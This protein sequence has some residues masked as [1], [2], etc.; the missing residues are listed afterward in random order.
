LTRKS[1]LTPVSG[2]YVK[3]FGKAYTLSG[4]SL[5]AAVIKHLREGHKPR[6]KLAA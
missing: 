1:C 5:S 3:S 4:E 2:R 6:E